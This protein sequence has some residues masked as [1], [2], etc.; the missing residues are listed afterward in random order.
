M[1]KFIES[2][3]DK[4]NERIVIKKNNVEVFVVIK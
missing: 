4:V 3:V 2:G 1:K